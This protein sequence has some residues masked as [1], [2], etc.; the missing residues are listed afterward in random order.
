MRLLNVFSKSIR[1]AKA[2]MK[3]RERRQCGNQSACSTHALPGEGTKEQVMLSCTGC[4]SQGQRGD[5]K[6]KQRMGNTKG[7][8]TEE[9]EWA[10][11][12]G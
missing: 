5:I 1:D 11:R 4:P 7:A 10:S 9:K 8:W 2:M 12:I 6:T 3:T